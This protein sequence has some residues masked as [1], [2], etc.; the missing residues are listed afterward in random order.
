[1]FKILNSIEQAFNSIWEA[2]EPRTWGRKL[3]DYLSIML[4][5]PVLLIMS[6]SATILIT[7]H[8]QQFGQAFSFLGLLSPLIE[9]LLKVLPYLLIWLLL[10]FLY[11]YLPNVKVNLLSGLMGGITAGPVFVLTQWAYITFQVGVA[12]YNAIYGSFAALPLFLIWMNLSWHIVLAG[13]ELTYA[14]QN[15]DI[16]EFDP[17]VSEVSASFRTL[18]TLHVTHH[19]VKNFGR[20]GK[21]LGAAWISEDL[22]VPRR[23]VREI[24][25]ALA[26][27]GIII[28]TSGSTR[29]RKIYHPARD[30]DDLTITFVL[31][32]LA[33]KG[34]DNIPV[35][36]TGSLKEIATSLDVFRVIVENSEAN[37]RLKDL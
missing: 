35:P 6:S 2:P 1:V 24:L 12:S 29:Y 32:A 3:S 16:Y 4:V 5:G 18:M 8:I 15:E 31:N 7:A 36:V 13:F 20:A 9:V 27:A 34:A 22:G 10:T 33:D 21:P 23:L 30:T 28:P 26:E 17:D 25:E 37:V 14:H 19:I 11:V